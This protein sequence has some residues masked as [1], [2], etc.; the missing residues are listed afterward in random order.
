ME[1][2]NFEKMVDNIKSF[3]EE[4]FPR[5]LTFFLALRRE[6]LKIVTRSG[7]DTPI[8]QIGNHLEDYIHYLEN[9]RK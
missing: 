2:V 1:Y 6:V 8:L 4:G 7:S 3:E 5:Y 9:G